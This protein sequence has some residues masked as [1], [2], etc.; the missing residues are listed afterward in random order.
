MAKPNKNP[1]NFSQRNFSQ[2]NFSQTALL[3]GIVIFAAKV[4]G[5]LRDVLVAQHYGTTPEAIA[6]ETASRLPVTVFDLVLGGVVTAAFIP[7]Y[8]SIAVKEGK[9]KALSFAQSYLNFI[10][11]VTTAL[12]VLGVAFAPA[13]V[14]FL[15]PELSSESLTLASYLTRI[16]FPMVIFCGMAFSF[17]G[18]LQSE[19]EYQVPAVISLVSNLI[20]VGYLVFLDRYFGVY[21]LAVSMLLGWAAQAAVQ[22]PSVT[23]HG[24]RFRL[25]APL[26]TEPIRRAAK[27]TLP[28]LI[29]TWTVPVCSL[30]NTRLASGI[31][32]GRAIMALGYANRLYIIIV[33][34][35]SFVATNLLFPVFSRAAASGERQEAGRL[36]RTS[37][38]TLVYLIAPI[39]AGIAALS[40]PFT[41]LL[42]EKGSFTPS[43]TLLTAEALRCYA[44]GMVFCAAN[45]VL[46]KA[47]FAEE[48]MKTPMTSALFAMGFNLAVLFVFGERLGVGG[49]AL[50]SGISTAVNLICNL[51]AAARRGVVRFTAADGRDL[52]KSVLSAVAMGGAVALTREGLLRLG[53]GQLISFGVPVL[54]GVL[55]YG[56]LTAATG[57]EE[58]KRLLSAVKEKLARTRSE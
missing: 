19:G 44:V 22:L 23:K 32:E 56:I 49:I 41:A 45:E 1:G 47:F 17:V 54:A 10:L 50:V 26:N 55:A 52:G 48:R 31:E 42:Y 16:L 35:F 8:N 21:G 33:G 57:S 6:Y 29:S 34:V 24:F 27:N 9:E 13:L 5:L 25:R 28:I 3:M 11:A 2:R 18:F 4:M 38:K 37:V 51:W 39:S 12:S 15:A 20:M 58:T 40:V 43:D 36:I 7:V 14:S 53:F 46:T 30:V